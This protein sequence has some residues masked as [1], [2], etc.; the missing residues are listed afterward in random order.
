MRKEAICDDPSSLENF[1]EHSALPLTPKLCAHS[2]A[3]WETF[4]SIVNMVVKQF[5]VLVQMANL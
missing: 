3:L 5:T 1:P 4:L 2:A